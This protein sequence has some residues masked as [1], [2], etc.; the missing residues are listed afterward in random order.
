MVNLQLEFLEF[1]DNIKLSYS[2]NAELRQKR[3]ILLRKLKDDISDEAATFSSFNQGSYAMHTGIKP[4]D[5]DYDI[6][7]GLRF[8]IDH[9]DYSDPVAVKQWVFDALNGHTK[10]V[11]IRRSCVT[12]T[13]Q[14]EGEVAYH[15]DFACY[16]DEID[17]LYIAKGKKNSSNE[18]RYWEESDPLGLIDKMKVRFSDE[19]E[20]AQFR[21][22]IRYMKKW[23]N[24]HFDLSGNNAPTGIAL[25][26][27]AYD[28][29]SAKYETNVVTGKKTYDDFSALK[30]FVGKVKSSFERHYDVND[31]KFYYTIQQNLFVLPYNDLFAKMTAK[32]QDAFYGKICTLLSKLEEV[33]KQTKKSEACSILT[34]IFGSDFPV[35]TERSYVG[36]SESA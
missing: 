29:F 17:N 13:Y 7:V 26:A 27:L 19:D 15:I 20:R 30:S 4:D 3:D 14:E 8:N 5:G 31:E 24:K 2:D 16:A 10:K 18:N 33:E 28:K 9:S 35:K 25:T 23:R 21:R 11:E 32:Q 6:D 34:D 36:H 12:V 22:I 1:H